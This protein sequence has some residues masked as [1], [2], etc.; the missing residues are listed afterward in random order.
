MKAL[1]RGVALGRP[2]ALVLLDAR[3]PDMDGLALAAIIR[4]RAELSGS[5]IVL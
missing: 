3:M 5:R 4:Q 2:Y 1:W